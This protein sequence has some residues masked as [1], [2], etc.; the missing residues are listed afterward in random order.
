M[1]QK[2]GIMDT[3]NKLRILRHEAGYSQ[4]YVA[5]FLGISKAKYCR[6]E[7]SVECNANFTVDNLLNILQLYEISFDDFQ[8]MTLPLVKR[9]KVPSSLVRKLEYVV[10]DDF[11][12]LSSSWQENR[13]KL[14]KI[15][16]VLFE[17]MDERAKIL[18]FPELD[19]TY[20]A[21]TGTTLKKVYLDTKVEQLIQKAMQVQKKF[22]NAIF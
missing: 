11:T 20:F 19:L 14:K 13:D 10:S 22:M 2:G 17:V 1:F 8:N 7:K 3:A 5:D 16:S 18:D 12:V 6:L 9:E 21:G 15:Q 4:Q